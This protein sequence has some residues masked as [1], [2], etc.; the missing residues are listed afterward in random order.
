MKTALVIG[1][2]PAGLAAAHALR[3]DAPDWRVVVLEATPHVGGISRTARFGDF[4]MDLGGHRFFSKSK[5]VNDIWAGLL[6]I[7]GA[8]SRDDIL[9]SR[10]CHVAPGGPDPEQTDLVMLRRPRVSRIYW[11]RH[12]L[13]YPVSLSPATFAAMGLPMT[14][15]AGAS[16]LRASL[17]PRPERSLEDFYVNRFGRVLYSAFFEGYTEKLWGVHPSRIAPDWG[18]QRVKGLSLWKA[19]ANVFT[20]SSKRRETS[21]ITE[22]LYPKYGPGQLWETL[23]DRLTADGVDLRLSAPVASLETAGPRIAAAR[24]ADGTRIPCDALFSSMPVKDLVAAIGSA[25]PDVARVAAVL[26]YRDFVAA[27]LL[28]SRLA[29][30]NRSRLPA[31]PGL[32]PDTWMYVQD[33]SVR[34]GRVQLFNNW[35]PYLLPDPDRQVWLGLEYFCAEGDDLWSLP[36]S[37]FTALAA[38]ELRKIGLLAPDAPVLRAHR[39]RVPKAYPAYC[40]LLFLLSPC[41]RLARHLLQPL[42]HRPQRPAPLQQHG[43]LH[44]HRPRSRPRPPRP[45]PPLLPLV[46]QRRIRLPRILT[47]PPSPEFCLMAPCHPFRHL[48]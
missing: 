37:D 31:L 34:L 21:L 8:P 25:P 1:A 36:D 33:S 11:R 18:A 40:R 5:A 24:I 39:V 30:P 22:F 35:S 46:R 23:A 6:P 4:R 17:A 27:G 3:R 28:V 10:P 41:P 43:P 26:P 13:D 38:S 19:L 16:F 15:S 14:L 42:L 12:F 9:L 2:G 32:V 47:F 45:L 48:Y 20:P 44:A 29:I 7:Q